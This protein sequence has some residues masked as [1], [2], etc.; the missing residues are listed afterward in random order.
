MS[1]Q[2]API[3][4][5]WQDRRRICGLPLS[6]TRYRMSEDRLFL[7]KGFFNLHM[8]EVLLYRVRD[9]TLT[10]SFG[11]RLFGMGTVIVYSSDKTL[12][13]FQLKNIRRSLWVK[14][15]IHEQVEEMKMQRRMRIS[16]IMGD[17]DLSMDDYDDEDLDAFDSECEEE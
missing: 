6:F 11:Q 16:E 4:Y 3:T 8:D 13:E 12:P 2:N 17:Q 10:R 15:L 7:M 9:I 1:R 14:E 5:I